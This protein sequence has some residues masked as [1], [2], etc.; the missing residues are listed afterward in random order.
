MGR[1][2][3]PGPP[4]QLPDR[5]TPPD[6]IILL[7]PLQKKKISKAGLLHVST[8]GRK[9]TCRTR[10]TT[11]KPIVDCPVSSVDVSLRLH[12]QNTNKTRG[13]GRQGINVLQT[14]RGH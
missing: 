13:R 2:A 4:F 9:L 11:T 14:S 5:S 3:S 7:K 1:A 6:G 10:H 8:Q 12:K